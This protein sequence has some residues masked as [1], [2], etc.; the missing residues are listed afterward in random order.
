MNSAVRAVGKRALG[1]FSARRAGAAELA[2]GE[3]F[4]NFL[5]S[6]RKVHCGQ[7][8]RLLVMNVECT[9][10]RKLDFCRGFRRQAK[11]FFF[12]LVREVDLCL[13]V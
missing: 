1:F 10:S 8:M 4:S 11:I 9:T 5:L 6:S 13:K 7:C 2:A 3:F 12:F